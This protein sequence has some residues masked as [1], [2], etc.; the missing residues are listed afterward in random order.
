MRIGRHHNATATVPLQHLA[1]AAQF[2]VLAED[3]SDGTLH[4]QIR[5]ELDLVVVGPA[6]TYRQWNTQLTSLCLR[7]KS[8][9]GALAKQAEFELR[10]RPL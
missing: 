8:G 2:G 1:N 6:D 10:H 4:A 7:Q 3:G 9:L 5:V